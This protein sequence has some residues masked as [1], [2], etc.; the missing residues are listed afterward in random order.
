MTRTSLLRSLDPRPF[1]LSRALAT[2]LVAVVP[3]C[4]GATAGSA[5]ADWPPLGK[6]WFERAQAS[7][8]S[9][10]TED[11]RLSIDNAL[12]V[13]PDS[14]EARLLSAKI[15]LADLEYDRAIE[16]LR[17][18]PGSEASAVRGRAYWYSGQVERAADE[19][20]RLLSDPDVRDPWAQDIARLARLGVGRTP[21]AVSGGMVAVTDMPRAGTTSLIVPLELNGE[22][23]LGMIATG[24]AEAVIDSSGGAQPS[25]VSIRFGERIEM[26]DIP[27]LAKDLT[28]ISRQVN[29]PIKIL[30]GANM[31]RHLR[32]TFDFAGG[33][34]VVRSFDPPQPPGATSVKLSYIRG[35]G[36]LLRGGFGPEGQ[37]RDCV[38]LVDT[39]LPYPVALDTAGWQKAGVDPKALELVSGAG[40]IRQGILPHLRIGGFDIPRVPGLDGTSMVKEREAGLGM[41]IDGLV[42]SGFLATFRVTLVDGGR[43]LWLEDLPPEAMQSAPRLPELPDAAPAESEAPSKPPAAPAPAVPRSEKKPAAAPPAPAAAAPTS[44]AP[45]KAGARTATPPA[46]APASAPPAKA[47]APTTAPATAGAAKGAPAAGSNATPAGGAAR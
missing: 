39:T 2:L 40:Q 9:G 34:F 1:S 27:A 7:F 24:A 38:L 15:A 26:R 44:A 29:A 18:V 21:F 41:D 30:L 11:A 46:A 3:A 25:W 22:P 13:V 23:A 19:L 28:G 17:D 10:D 43:T 14:T 20:D 35:G 5:D 6:K 42:G 33:Q 45:D 36:M 12:R 32:P 31:L 47:G 4:G 8:Q 37:G 16:A